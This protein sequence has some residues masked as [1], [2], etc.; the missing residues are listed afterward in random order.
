M[1]SSE[2]KLLPFRLP[3]CELDNGFRC[4]PSSYQSMPLSYTLNGGRVF[5]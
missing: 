5:P 4:A 1:E 2:D 3:M